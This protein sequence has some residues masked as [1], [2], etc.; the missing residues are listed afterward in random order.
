[1]KTNWISIVSIVALL[2]VYVTGC[3]KE[4]GISDAD[5][6]TAEDELIMD[7]AYDDV[8][9]EVDGIMN[10]MD[11]Y[12][13]ELSSLKS[14]MADTC[15]VISIVTGDSIWPRTIVVDYGN[16]CDVSR[17][18]FRE[19]IRR[20]KIQIKVSGP[21]WQEGSYREVTFDN[22]YINDYKV[23]GRRT[24]T[25]EGTWEAGEY[26]GLHYFS[27]S[28]DGGKVTTPEGQEISREV[29]HTRTFVEGFN[30][31]WDIRD[32]VWYINGVATGVNRK[33]VAYKRE[34]TSPLWKE[35]GC[36]FITHGTLL[37]QTEGRPDVTM[38]Y[39]DGSCDPVVT[40]TVN[41]ETREVKLRKW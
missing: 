39:G 16:G 19:R 34:I 36:R 37:I 9:S 12:G 31:K 21:M 29:D 15:P 23:E 38:D 30:T 3:Q 35:I 13:Y 1:M 10:Q 28:L 33:G 14:V 20:G 8:F 11:Q 25:N 6:I 18:L 5:L 4:P 41:D 40:V 32:D 24:V 22:F 17:N 26:Q 2:T 7:A 27:I